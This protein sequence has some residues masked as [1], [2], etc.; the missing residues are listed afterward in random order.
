LVH[1]RSVDGGCEFH[2]DGVEVLTCL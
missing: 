2:E 1:A